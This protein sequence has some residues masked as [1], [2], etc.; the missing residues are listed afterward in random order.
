MRMASAQ[1]GALTNVGIAPTPS[2]AAKAANR[3][4]IKSGTSSS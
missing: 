2:G 4:N 1:E 3:L